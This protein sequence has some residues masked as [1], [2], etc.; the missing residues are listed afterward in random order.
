MF[1][2]LRCELLGVQEVFD[3]QALRD[4]ATRSSVMKKASVI[5]P[6]ADGNANLPRVGLVTRLELLSEASSSETLAEQFQITLPGAPEIGI[7][8]YRH[9]SFSRPVL[10]VTVN[11]A[12]A[13][14]SV[15][16]RVYVVHLKSRRPK[17][18]QSGS[19][20]SFVSEDM[21]NPV[22]ETRAH[23]RSLMI[24]AAESAAL[25]YLVLNDLHG[26]SMP[27]IVLGD[28]NDHAKA[29]TTELVTGRMLVRQRERRDILLWHASALQRPNALKRD[30]GYTKIHLDEPDSIDHILLSEEFLRE[31]KRS[32][33]EV[34]R[35][36]YFNDHLNE[37][38]VQSQSDHGAIRATLLLNDPQ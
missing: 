20:E 14:R 9:E 7:A 18:L 33:G 24:R 22:I 27:V 12:H 38:S 30:L 13:G 31:S 17:R 21:D 2:Q 3:E 34:L 32:I 35:V 5:A 23:L 6:G 36:D 26:T 29:M 15:P 1:D 37:K 11:L 25:R 8:D 10:G 4:C 28:F 16:A 19:G